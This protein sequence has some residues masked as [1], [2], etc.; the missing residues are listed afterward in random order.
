[1]KEKAQGET[2]ACEIEGEKMKAREYIRRDKRERINYPIVKAHRRDSWP[3]TRS[4]KGYV[5]DE[6]K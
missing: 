3:N 6:R 4:L 5:N 2:E 1:M